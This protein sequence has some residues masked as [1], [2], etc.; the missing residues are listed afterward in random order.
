MS[1]VAHTQRIEAV[2]LAS[3]RNVARV[4]DAAYE[5]DVAVRDLIESGSLSLIPHQDGPFSLHLA[6]DSGN[7]SLRIGT[8]AGET[9]VLQVSMAPFRRLI[10]DYFLICES[11]IEATKWARNDH[12]QTL[13]MARRGI[14][15]EGAE[16]LKSLL[17]SKAVMDFNTARRIFTLMCVLHIA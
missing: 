1:E 3:G 8:G 2:T 15:N 9:R 14:H 12:L 5:R 17:D 10:K 11:H 13:D 6:M 16:L 4:S 7:V